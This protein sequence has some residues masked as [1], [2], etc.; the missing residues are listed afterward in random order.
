MSKKIIYDFLDM[1]AAEYG[2][3]SNTVSAYEGDLLQLFEFCD[4]EMIDI[5]EEDI[6]DFIK[7][8]SSSGYAASSILRKI[9]ALNDFFKFL[10]SEKEINQNP[11]LNINSPK[12]AKMLPKFLTNEEVLHLI[13]VA[14]QIDKSKFL[15]ISVMIKLMYACGL[16]VSELVGLSFNCINFDKKQILIKG[17]GGKERIV[18]IADD[19]QR[20]VLKWFDER[21]KYLNKSNKQFLF[22][23]LKSK[24]GH[25]SR[26]SFFRDIKELALIAGIE[27]DKISPHV[28][29]HSFATHLLQKDVDLR[30]IQTI[31]GHEDISTTE[32]YTHIQPQS[33]ITEIK[34]KH[35]LAKY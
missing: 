31:L 10:L 14:E 21:K 18:P 6:R 4:K 20:S 25:V 7:D 19:A 12:K 11:M 29:R 2:V 22:P 27:Q 32:I 5:K 1:L 15:K 35:P 28:L 34:N 16:R 9:S 3:A 33:L 30:S 13:E 23:S 8:L 24:T 26:N 17:K